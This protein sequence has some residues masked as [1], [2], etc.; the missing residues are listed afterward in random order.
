MKH[1]NQR[2]DKSDPVIQQ[3][4]LQTH[5]FE[6]GLEVPFLPQLLCVLSIVRTASGAVSGVVVG[7]LPG[8]DGSCSG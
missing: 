6:V 2:W 4:A 1:S 3:E 8:G 5:T 7:G